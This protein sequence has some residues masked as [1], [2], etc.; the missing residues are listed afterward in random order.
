M[1]SA[2][3][4]LAWHAFPSPLDALPLCSGRAASP[5]WTRLPGQTWLGA[6]ASFLAMWGVMMM[7]MMLPSLMPVLWRYRCAVRQAGGPC[8]DRLALRA[9]A[10]YF[11]VWMALG[12]TLYPLGA[13]WGAMRQHI[14][15]LGNVDPFAVGAVV[16]L[17]GAIQS[18]RWKARHMTHCRHAPDAADTLPANAS[19]A[20]KL[21]LRLGKHCVCSCTGLTLMLLAM[22]AMNVGVMAVVTAIITIERLA[23]QGQ[24]L[25]RASGLGMVATALFL[26]AQA[27]PLA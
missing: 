5:L 13:L 2:A 20:W 24:R 16:L 11:F 7:A 23:P 25:A 27:R 26:L 15:A 8:G 18:S 17:A 1:G 4:T 22:G 10:G 14:S 3:T 12:A 19:A 6:A 9:G 21:G